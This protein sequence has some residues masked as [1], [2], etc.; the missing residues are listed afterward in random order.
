MAEPS[1]LTLARLQSLPA[2][3]R[4]DALLD[5][6]DAKA[7][8]RA[9]P[10]QLLYQTIAEVGLADSTE[11]VQLASSEQFRALVDLGGWDRDRL[12]PLETLTWLRAARGDDPDEFFRKLRAVDLEVVELILRALTVIHDRDEDPDVDPQGVTV[13]TP[14]GKYLI[15]LRV[16]GAPMAALRTLINDFIAQ[17]P[18]QASRL[19]EAVRWEVPTEMEET[20]HRFRTGRLQDLGFPP[21]DEAMAIYAWVDPGPL[22]PPAPE[23]LKR[24]GGDARPDYLGEALRALPQGEREVL[25]EE[26]RL[27]INSALVADA[28][29]P[30]ELEDLRRVGEQTRDYLSLGFE[31]L[32]GQDPA[33]AV[34]AVAEHPLKEIFQV[35]FSLTLQLKR[36]A[37]RLSRD[38]FTISGETPLL[39]FERASF[40]ALRRKRP[41]RAVK[42]EGADPMPFRS[43]RELEESV[44]LLERVG[45]QAEVFRALV[46]PDAAE[47]V[48][49]FGVPFHRLGADRLFA[50]AA[51]HAVLDGTFQ[52]A[53]VPPAR[54]QELGGRLFEGD[55]AAPALRKAAPERALAAL[56]PAVP[57]PL[58]AELRRMVDAALAR[59]LRDLGAAFL[60]DGRMDPAAAEAAV[61]LEG[62][63]L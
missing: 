41:M 13:E 54:L 43:R 30:G 16:E 19:F 9:L 44:Q 31:L 15:E 56:E 4:M 24:A 52:V 14:E 22:A 5:E 6:R 42:V 23:G 12:N 2:K 60:R 48:K 18:F 55:A 17:D 37:D 46:A 33:R 61:G 32:T 39:A 11:L 8:V 50:S 27:L 10:I 47:V 59:W 25:E 1:A 36:K 62:P 49:R 29:D 58:R 51:A 7:A 34:A 3:K 26:L 63:R 38:L 28:A 35:G 40:A 20:A 45:Q 53:P 57:E 21:L